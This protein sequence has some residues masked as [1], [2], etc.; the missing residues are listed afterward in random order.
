MKRSLKHIYLSSIWWKSNFTHLEVAARDLDEL[1]CFGFKQVRNKLQE[2]EFQAQ[3]QSIPLLKL[4]IRIHHGS[5][6]CDS[7]DSGIST[8]QISQTDQEDDGWKLMQKEIR[9]LV[10]DW[11]RIVKL[12][13]LSSW[14]KLRECERF[15]IWILVIVISVMINKCFWLYMVA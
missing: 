13:V 1:T 11:G 9:V 12:K 4:A 6:S 2:V 7:H 3:V 5:S 15:Q 10:Q 8:V 14:W